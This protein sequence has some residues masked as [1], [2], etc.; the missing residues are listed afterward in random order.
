MTYNGG[1]LWI[2]Q[3]GATLDDY[4]T[5]IELFGNNVVVG[6][7]WNDATFFG[8]PQGFGYLAS[9]TTAGVKNWATNFVF[10]S[11]IYSVII[12][13]NL[14]QASGVYNSSGSNYELFWRTFNPS[15]GALVTSVYQAGDTGNN[16]QFMKGTIDPVNEMK[17]LVGTGTDDFIMTICGSVVSSRSPLAIG[18]VNG[19]AQDLISRR[20]WVVGV[21]G[22]NGVL[23]QESAVTLLA[24]GCGT[25][26]TAGATTLSTTTASIMTTTTTTTT[27]STVT[28]TIVTTTRTSTPSTTTTISS[29]TT[30]KATTTTT[31]ST[32]TTTLSTT[33]IN[34]TA[35][36]T[37][38]M[39]S[40]ITSIT[41]T[42]A[43]TTFMIMSP[44]PSATTIS[45]YST[46][47]PTTN[48]T[49]S[50]EVPTTSTISSIANSSDQ[51]TATSASIALAFN[52]S[53][54]FNGN[55]SSTGLSH[56]SA[57]VPSSISLSSHL[58]S[59][60]SRAPFSFD[61]N[62]VDGGATL[63][64]TLT[65]DN[66]LDVGGQPLN[67]GNSS[68]LS[69]VIAGVSGIVAFVVLSVLVVLYLQRRKRAVAQAKKQKSSTYGVIAGTMQMSTTQTSTV[70]A[71]QGRAGQGQGRVRAGL[72][73]G[74]G[75]GRV[76]VRVR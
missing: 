9:Y 57:F 8:Q 56:T 18:A 12:R 62:Y 22:F 54:G 2:V 4:L 69:N 66:N 46:I 31:T 45:T 24:Q 71:G 29:T 35:T 59:L 36:P 3:E 40:T 26:T 7:Y 73:Q 60:S 63:Q 50:T 25:T 19:I 15:T 42:T 16:L 38:T 30:T 33:S 32:S 76:R 52:S 55:F 14:I 10:K 70:R 21:S 1:Q 48:S 49:S 72:G 68:I 47:I 65:D 53:M 13:D 6:G 64:S 17:V 23:L 37:S 5:S 74:Q 67:S 20:F 34:A 51:S 27:T 39:L 44:T 28:E 41:P 58:S 61:Y 43:V 11:A 75:Q